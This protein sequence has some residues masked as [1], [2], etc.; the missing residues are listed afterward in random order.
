MMCKTKT[1]HKGIGSV[2]GHEISH[3]FDDSGRQYDG[4]GNQRDWWSEA[5]VEAFK[6]RAQCIV[7]QYNS[8]EVGGW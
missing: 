3:G 8:F 2:I 6:K 1:Q 5:V 4:Q 7:D